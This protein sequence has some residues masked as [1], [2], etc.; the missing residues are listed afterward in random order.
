MKGLKIAIAKVMSCLSYI[1]RC[2]TDIYDTQMK[3]LKYSRKGY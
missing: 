3:F 2:K 1:Y